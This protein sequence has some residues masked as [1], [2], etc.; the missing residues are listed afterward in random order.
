MIGK[1]KASWIFRGFG[2]EKTQRRKKEAEGGKK[3]LED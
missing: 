3:K 2:V 1:G